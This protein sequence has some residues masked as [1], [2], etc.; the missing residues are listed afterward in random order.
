MSSHVLSSSYPH[1]YKN[2][3]GFKFTCSGSTFYE[4]PI[5][6]SGALFDGSIRP[7]PDRVVFEYA[8]PVSCRGHLSAHYLLCQ[9]LR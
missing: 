7:G 5:L 4:F 2:Y 8:I 9:P 6:A 3:E 1:Q